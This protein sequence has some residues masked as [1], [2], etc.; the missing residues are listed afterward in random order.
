M[1]FSVHAVFFF[2]E[3]I[4]YQNSWSRNK[5]DR[6]RRPDINNPA[7]SLLHT[8]TEPPVSRGFVQNRGCRVKT[9]GW[10][11][12]CFS[13]MI[14]ISFRHLLLR[15]LTQFS[16]DVCVQLFVVPALAVPW[17]L[18]GTKH[19]SGS[20]AMYLHSA[21]HQR[22]NRLFRVRFWTTSRIY[23]GIRL[24]F[25]LLFGCECVVLHQFNTGFAII[26]RK[27]CWP[28]PTAGTVHPPALLQ[29]VMSE[30]PDMS[31]VSTTCGKPDEKGS[32]MKYPI[33]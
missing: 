22:Y 19:G 1:M 6:T 28:N 33:K 31:D 26:Y 12:F 10:G 23:N 18:F 7:P 2:S 17:A 11:W 3:S 16:W 27:R 30:G 9:V 8:S 4:K 32:D 14:A 21:K 29:P 13:A 25:V 5:N 15:K 24:I 20:H